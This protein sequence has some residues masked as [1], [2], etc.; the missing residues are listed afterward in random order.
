MYEFIRGP[1]AWTCFGI[2]ILGTVSQVVYFF[3]LT[4][5]ADKTFSTRPPVRKRSKVPEISHQTI[6]ASLARLRVSIVGVNPGMVFVT[7]IFHVSIFMLPIF[8]MEHNMLAEVLWGFSF[9]PH[10]LS[11]VS[12]DVMTATVLACVLFF[13]ARRIFIKRVRAISSFYDYLILGLTTAPFIT[14]ILAVHDVFDYNTLIILHVLS[15]NMILISIPFTKI[16][17]MIFFFLNRFF[18]QGEYG[19]GRGSRA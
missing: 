8:L 5:K 6:A 12:T 15:V 4:R 10:V 14:G 2:F 9:C 3:L 1:L 16:A 17:H 13:L 7:L 19:F 11:E 18:I